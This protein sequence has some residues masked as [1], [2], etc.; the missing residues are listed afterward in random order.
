VENVWVVHTGYRYG[1]G[2]FL[3]GTVFDDLDGD[4]SMDAG[5]GL[6]GVTVTAGGL[7]ATT[8]DG[9]GYSIEVPT[10]K[11]TISAAGPG[12]EG[13]STTTIR[14][15]DYNVNADFISG[16]R[17]PV[18]RD[19]QLC[20]GREPTIL[21][22]NG[23]DVIY[24]TDGPDVIHG[25]AGKD[26]IYGLRGNDVICGGGD[27]DILYGGGGKD[28]LIGGWGNDTIYGNWGKDRLIGGPAT[29]E[30]YGGMATDTCLTGET[31]HSCP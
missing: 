29:D 23:N 17:K 10:G 5:E 12:F 28:R 18:V 4:G 31:L 24:G 11:H 26:T 6:P 22:T 25:L 9:G 16:T 7:T 1:T 3:T 8:N 20:R 21:G 19:Y 30:L 27:D 15:I 13:T 14:V 2:V